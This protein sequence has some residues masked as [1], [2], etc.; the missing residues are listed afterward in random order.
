MRGRLATTTGYRRP[1]PSRSVTPVT[2]RSPLGETESARTLP[3][4]WVPARRHPSLEWSAKR[5]S[6]PEQGGQ[7]Y[8]RAS[9]EVRMAPS[10]IHEQAVT[11]IQEALNAALGQSLLVDM[12]CNE[13]PDGHAYD[14]VKNVSTLAASP[15]IGGIFPDLVCYDGHGRPVTFVEVVLTNEPSEQVRLYAVKHGINL[16]EVHLKKL[17]DQPGDQVEKRKARREAQEALAVKRRLQDLDAGKI[18]VDEHNQLCQRP[19]CDDCRAPLPERTI[20]ISVKNCWKC[21][22]PVTVATGALSGTRWSGGLPPSA[23]TKAER[24]FAE[25]N[26][27]ILQRRFSATQRA[28]DV[29][30]VCPLCDQIQGNWYL[31]I[32]PYHDRYMIQKTDRKT[33]GPCDRCAE[34][35]C[36]TH[37]EYYV[38][39]DD[40]T[41]PDCRT[42]AERVHCRV[43][44]DRECFY[45]EQCADKGCYFTRGQEE[46]EEP[47][48]VAVVHEGF[49]DGGFT[50]CG[51]DRRKLDR[52]VAASTDRLEVTCELCL[53]AR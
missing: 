53:R 24:E 37:G 7:V 22:A 38:Y 13:C 44:A 36:P 9:L 43:V 18:R 26:G 17:S 6:P 31:Y 3:G 30:N 32:D 15:R 23:F 14:L 42:E 50:G 8:L 25:A 16:Y 35:T 27:A 28:K 29:C 20:S 33:Y 39:G 1:P 46:Q 2:Q 4:V 19:R 5:V 49:P 11:A 21:E 10:D 34:R 41:C 48:K 47:H 52:D 45:P 51:I 40:S 12:E